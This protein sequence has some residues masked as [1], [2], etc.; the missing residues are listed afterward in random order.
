MIKLKKGKKVVAKGILKIVYEILSYTK[1]S[2]KVRNI[3][4]KKEYHIDRDR[5]YNMVKE[6]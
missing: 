4:T 2:V 1:K 6:I 3:K 5:F